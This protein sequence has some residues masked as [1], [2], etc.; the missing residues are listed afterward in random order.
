[1]LIQPWAGRGGVRD[2]LP[3]KPTPS[4]L[5]A[6]RL[7]LTH[8]PQLSFFFPPICSALRAKTAGEGGLGAWRPASPERQQ[9]PAPLQPALPKALTV[10][11]SP[12]PGAG[13]PQAAVCLAPI[14]HPYGT[15]V[16]DFTA[17]RQ[18]DFWA[19]ARC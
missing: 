15:L 17:A 9:P 18:G 1:M 10:H 5:R 19:A 7:F 3:S 8:K 4:V 16:L 2:S 13:R 11:V 12:L 14:H 6:P